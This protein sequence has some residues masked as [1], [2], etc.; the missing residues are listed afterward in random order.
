MRYM[1]TIILEAAKMK[2][3]QKEILIEG[4]T[5][6]AS[7]TLRIPVEAFHVFINEYETDNI[8]TAG[9]MLTKVIEERKQAKIFNKIE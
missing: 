9:K 8:G 1:P 3:E 5:R 2:I 6:L 4:L 7:E